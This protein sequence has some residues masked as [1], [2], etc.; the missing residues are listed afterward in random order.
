[1]QGLINKEVDKWIRPWEIEKEDFNELSNKDER[2]FSLL[3]KGALSWLNDNIVMYNKPI[4]HFIFNTGSSYLYLEN[5]GYEYTFCETTGEDTLYMKTPRC[6]VSLGNFSV[7]LEELTAKENTAQYERISNADDTKGQIL[8][9]NAPMQRIPLELT[10]NL[11]YVFSTFNESI[12][13]VQELFE[14]LLFQRYFNIVYLGQTIQCSIEFTENTNININQIDLTSRETNQKTIELEVKICSNLPVFNIK[15]EVRSA[16]VIDSFDAPNAGIYH[17]K[18][19]EKLGE[20]RNR[21]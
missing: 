20:Y 16:A 6:V 9:Y 7:I 13:F 5:N 10:L 8:A 2:F 11:K 3:I 17:L 4:N 15:S 12:I 14:K 1:M 21:E 18:S 19:K